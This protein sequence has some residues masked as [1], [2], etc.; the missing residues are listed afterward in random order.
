M[1]V[2]ILSRSTK[3]GCAGDRSRVRMT[4]AP[5]DARDVPLEDAHLTCKGILRGGS[6][7]QTRG[8]SDDD[9]LNKFTEYL[10][11][12]RGSDTVYQTTRVNGTPP[13]DV[14]TSQ[15]AVCT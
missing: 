15:P 9:I 1:L 8:C 14:H 3:T 7:M 6:I 5:F 4:T 10:Q 13:N 11:T 2:C 12:I